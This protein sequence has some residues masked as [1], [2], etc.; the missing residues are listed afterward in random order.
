VDQAITFTYNLHERFL[1][2]IAK[3]ES[4]YEA[5]KSA[6]EKPS[7]RRLLRAGP[8][9]LA[10]PTQGRI[11]YAALTETVKSLVSRQSYDEAY[12]KEAAT[13]LCYFQNGYFHTKYRFA[14]V[15]E[16]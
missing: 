7:K 14:F 11:F 15:L 10:S 8:T 3:P 4:L 2:D 16:I 1:D 6:K 13:N 12:K 9:S 5:F